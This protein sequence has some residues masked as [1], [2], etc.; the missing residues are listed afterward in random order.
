M[1][2]GTLAPASVADFLSGLL[3]GD[4]LRMALVAGWAEPDAPVLVVGEDALCARYLQAAP[5]FGL[6]LQPTPGS[7]AAAGLR[8]VAAAAGLLHGR[9]HA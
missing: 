1:L 6:T 5:A 2:E 8:Q 4:A 3:I 9:T 7:T